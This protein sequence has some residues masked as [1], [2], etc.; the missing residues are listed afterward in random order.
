MPTERADRLR[1]LV[2]L[3][4]LAL[5]ATVSLVR[6]VDL[7]RHG[8]SPT[9]PGE[10]RWLEWTAG[11]PW[12]RAARAALREETVPADER[13]IE[14]QIQAAGPVR[15]DWVQVMA[16]YDRPGLR[17]LA[18]EV[19]G[20][21]RSGPEASKLPEHAVLRVAVSEPLAANLV[22]EPISVRAGSA[23]LRVLFYG[24]L[25]LLVAGGV[26]TRATS[27]WERVDTL[28]WGVLVVALA[29]FAWK[30]IEA[31]LWSWDH[32]AIWGLKVR[33]LVAVGL[34]PGWLAPPAFPYSAPQYPLGWPLLVAPLAAVTGAGA[35]L[36]KTVH[37]LCGVALA[38]LVR[39]AIRRG[40]GDRLTATT[41]ASLTAVSPL[42]WDTE[43]L[44][45]A[46]LPLALCAVAG[47]V[48]FLTVLRSESVRPWL[49]VLAG[50]AF[51]FLPWMKT[52]GWSLSTALL[53][54]ASLMG[55]AR[56]GRRLLALLLPAVTLWIL[57]FPFHAAFTSPGTG[58]FAGDWPGRVLD[59][60]FGL[61]GILGRMGLVLVDPA[62]LGVWI[63]FLAALAWAVVRRRGVGR[64]G[65]AIL[66]AGVV[67]AQ[68]GVYAFVYLATYLD[69]AAHID[70]SFL[71]IAAALVPL[72]VIAGGVADVQEHR[73]YPKIPLRSLVV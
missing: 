60:I 50:L 69:P 3:A 55:F 4:L 29:V 73:R 1:R 54:A 48:A 5:V 64:Q 62:W 71:R 2:L 20:Q 31:P 45:L 10:R 17:V 19:E 57:Y 27:A 24:I 53:G 6:A 16:Q 8:W 70:S 25:L 40:G 28:A 38:L 47:L 65:P 26:L 37:V 67:L 61:P 21:E 63:L 49:L 33:R 68:L 41:A 39:L 66:L 7:A 18:V 32:H 35:A 51:G 11:N 9:A 43:S 46:D 44:G 12:E 59:R 23:R 72:A 22:G 58:F 52:E 30:V 34:F 42:F 14:V 15:A 56:L 36:F 13:E